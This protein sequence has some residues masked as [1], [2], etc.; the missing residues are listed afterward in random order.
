MN[1]ATP[2][3]K[4]PSREEAEAAVR[5][6]IA[7]AGDNPAR[8]GLVETPKRVV[9]T[10]VPLRAANGKADYPAAKAVAEAAA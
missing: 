4:R 10:E 3:V 8:P 2:P 5:T 9:A 1:T 7:W 6:L